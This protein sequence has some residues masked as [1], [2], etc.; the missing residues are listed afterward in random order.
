M[1]ATTSEVARGV[2][3]GAAATGT[4]GRARGTTGARTTWTGALQGTVRSVAA[5]GAVTWIGVEAADERSRSGGATSDAAMPSAARALAAGCA[6][7]CGFIPACA[8]CRAGLSV[9]TTS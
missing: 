8:L 3:V 5:G 2:N 1:R 6:N 4:A 7:D 9:Q